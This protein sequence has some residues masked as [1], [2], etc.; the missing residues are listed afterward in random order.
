ML[1][2]VMIADGLASYSQAMRYQLKHSEH[3]RLA[4]IR[5]K[6]NNSMVEHLHNTLREKYK[7]LRGYKAMQSAEALLMGQR[8]Y[9]N[10]VRPHMTLDKTPAERAGIKLKL[11]ENSG[12]D[13]YN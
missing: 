8:V 6:V 1:P 5:D 3:I 10:F 2:A 13:W 12:W 7:V 11:G 4:G 9:Y